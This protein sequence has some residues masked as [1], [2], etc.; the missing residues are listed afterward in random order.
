MTRRRAAQ[1]VIRQ[2]FGTPGLEAALEEVSRPSEDLF[3]TF[4]DYQLDQEKTANDIRALRT[5]SEGELDKTDRLIW[6]TEEGMELL[7]KSLEAQIE[8]LTSQRD[9]SVAAEQARVT[10]ADAAYQALSDGFAATREELKANWAGI[11]GVDISVRSVESATQGVESAILRVEPATR[12]VESATRA[13]ELATQNL[14]SITQGVE[15]AVLDVA[16]ATRDVESATRAVELAT[17]EVAAALAQYEI[18]KAA[19]DALEATLRAT[20]RTEDLAAAA[21]A[22]A[23]RVATATAVR[24]AAAAAYSLAQQQHTELLEAIRDLQLQGPKEPRT[25]GGGGG[26]GG[27]AGGPLGGDG[28]APVGGGGGHGFQ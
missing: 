11:N 28:G 15:P 13:V 25:P 9:S 12:D 2:G 5:S 6:A 1:G 16:S 27:A 21:Q 18:A 8:L 19:A 3:K 26:V 20:W 10:D 23:D 17:Q 7:S 4:K 14:A 24:D 22:T